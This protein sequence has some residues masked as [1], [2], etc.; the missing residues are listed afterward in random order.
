[1]LCNSVMMLL[2]IL[3]VGVVSMG[4]EGGDFNITI[5]TLLQTSFVYCVLI[6]LRLLLFSHIVLQFFTQKKCLPLKAL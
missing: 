3:C 6:V 2:A 5:S 1:M 4:D